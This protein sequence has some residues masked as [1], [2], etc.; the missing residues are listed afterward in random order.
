M[1]YLF[2]YLIAAEVWMQNNPSCKVQRQPQSN[3]RN[4]GNQPISGTIKPVGEASRGGGSVPYSQSQRP[5]S[6]RKDTSFHQNPQGHDRTSFVPPPYKQQQNSNFKRNAG[7]GSVS[8]QSQSP[9][10]FIPAYRAA[11]A[12]SGP[13]RKKPK[14]EG[15]LFSI[16][17]SISHPVW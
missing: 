13:S 2:T 10:E 8:Q 3:N 1:L 14:K 6:F 11:L 7:G 16:F 5:S 17:F 9:P 4:P 12:P 15:A